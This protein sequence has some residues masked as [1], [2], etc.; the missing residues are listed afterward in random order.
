M[1]SKECTYHALHFTGDVCPYCEEI[2]TKQN[3]TSVIKY[4]RNCVQ[5]FSS[6]VD[7]SI[8][9]PSMMSCRK[10]GYSWSISLD[11]IKPLSDTETLV[12]ADIRKRQSL[13]LA[14]YGTT[15]AMNPLELRQWL[16][17]QYEE[18]LDAAIYCKRAIQEIDKGQS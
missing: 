10:C 8:N 3:N 11:R 5:C 18:L 16:Q 7:V 9:N 6:D 13:G 15:V 12:I 1:I 17:H 14:K 2:I 4:D